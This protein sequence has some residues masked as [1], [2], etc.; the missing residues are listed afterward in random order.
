MD[1][2]IR[3]APPPKAHRPK[4][5]KNGTLDPKKTGLL[6]HSNGT[7]FFGT[8]FFGTIFF[9]TIFYGTVEPGKKRG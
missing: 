4:Q 6:H 9:G 7:I 3:L 8:I 5:K 1:P 2:E